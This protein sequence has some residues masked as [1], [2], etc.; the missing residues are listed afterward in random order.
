MGPY[1]VPKNFLGQLADSI[2][3]ARVGWG[4]PPRPRHSRGTVFRGKNCALFCAHPLSKTVASGSREVG[5][6]IAAT[7]ATIQHDSESSHSVIIVIFRTHNP[8]VP[9]SS[10]G[11]P[12]IPR[13]ITFTRLAFPPASSHFS[14]AD[15]LKRRNFPARG[16][17]IGSRPF[18][19]R[20]MNS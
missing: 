1:A 18:A 7:G 20:R 4:D 10:P 6:G 16:H 13:G 3:I 19:H 2:A 11:G 8:P 5:A 17:G 12:T 14:I 15:H 9:G